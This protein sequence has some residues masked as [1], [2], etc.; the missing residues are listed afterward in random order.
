MTKKLAAELI[1]FLIANPYRHKL[2]LQS[3]IKNWK[4]QGTENDT[5]ISCTNMQIKMND[6]FM[7]SL[8]RLKLI[9]GDT[10]KET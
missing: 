2:S 6:T 5:I 7:L 1:S 3:S 9:L 10:P 8:Y 4:E